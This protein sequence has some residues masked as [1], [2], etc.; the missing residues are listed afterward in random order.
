MGN[1][2]AL[3]RLPLKLESK[4]SNENFINTFDILGRMPLDASKII[5]A[6]KTD[7]DLSLVRDY[8]KSDEWPKIK[9]K[10]VSH[11]FNRKEELNVI[12]DCLMLRQRVVIPNKLKEG[13]LDILHECHIGIV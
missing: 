13:V 6:Q 5:E 10:L 7:K 1:A 8:I 11:L 3:S 2:D 9:S 12:E 4:L